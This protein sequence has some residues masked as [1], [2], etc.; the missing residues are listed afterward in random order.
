MIKI[1]TT[2]QS[3][4][5]ESTGKHTPSG[6]EQSALPCMTEYDINT[7]VRGQRRG[8]LKG[9]GQQ[10]THMTSSTSSAAASS[11]TSVPSL[12]LAEQAVIPELIHQ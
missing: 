4:T 3:Q 7:A 6:S 8:H 1:R 5:R 9:V 11:S 2:L 12:T 10:L